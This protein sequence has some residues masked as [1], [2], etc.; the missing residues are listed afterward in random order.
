VVSAQVQM[1]GRGQPQVQFGDGVLTGRVTFQTF[2]QQGELKAYL[3]QQLVTDAIPAALGTFYAFK[4]DA[5]R[6][7]APALALGWANRGS[8]VRPRRLEY[9]SGRTGPV[10]TSASGQPQRARACLAA[11][12][13]RDAAS[14]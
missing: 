13:R 10:R 2:C 6:L 8:C 7:R 5:L 3:E 1:A 11:H 9:N 14:R 12:C 4:D